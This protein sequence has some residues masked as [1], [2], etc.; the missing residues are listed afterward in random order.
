M[1]GI[2]LLVLVLGFIVV[3]RILKQKHDE[4]YMEILITYPFDSLKKGKVAIFKS[5]EGVRAE[6]FV[7]IHLPG[8]EMIWKVVKKEGEKLWLTNRNKE[9]LT[10]FP[11]CHIWGKMIGYKGELKEDDLIENV[12]GYVKS[13]FDKKNNK[14]D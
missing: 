4:T 1:I 10:G 5:G 8:Y 11:A 9:E 13:I 2:T 12:P 7:L 6:D 3:W 14:E